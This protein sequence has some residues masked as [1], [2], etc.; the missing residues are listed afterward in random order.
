MA[1]AEQHACSAA[2]QASLTAPGSEQ[3]SESF[4]Y[5]FQL[6]ADSQWRKKKA[7]LIGIPCAFYPS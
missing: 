6:I 2:L 7:K 1:I 4:L 3:L 5:T